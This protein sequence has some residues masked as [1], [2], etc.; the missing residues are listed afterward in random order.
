[1]PVW[2]RLVQSGES[3][4]W[5]GIKAQ[6]IFRERNRIGWLVRLR[7]AV[8]LNLIVLRQQQNAG[9]AMQGLGAALII[10][11]FA[12]RMV[13]DKVETGNLSGRCVQMISDLE[14]RETGADDNKHQHSECT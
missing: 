11:S 1:M 12:I 4:R 6:C 3:P 14:M 9:T 7:K 5:R 2:H 10:R 13:M 8:T